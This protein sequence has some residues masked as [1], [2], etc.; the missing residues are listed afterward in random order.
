MKTLN[1]T[2]DFE[3]KR[4]N[5]QELIIENGLLNGEEF[6]IN[7]VNFSDL[8]FKVVD[9]KADETGRIPCSEPHCECAFYGTY[10]CPMLG[11]AIDDIVNK[12]KM[13]VK[14]YNGKVITTHD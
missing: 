4:T 13:V 2:Y 8:T 3:K 5:I 6:K 10:F 7:N 11:C 9:A 12:N 1:Y 14:L